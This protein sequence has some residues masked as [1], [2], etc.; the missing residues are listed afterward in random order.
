MLEMTFRFDMKNI[1]SQN[2]DS[3]DNGDFEAGIATKI[4]S[5]NKR[6][7]LYRVILLNDDYTPM[8]FV[9]HILQEIFNKSQDEA[10]II[11]LTVH[12]QGAGECGIFSFEIAET[13]VNQ[14]LDLA[15]KDQHPLKCVM[16]KQ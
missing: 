9:V 5:K 6:P 2:G 11:M 12:N 16:Q 1:S 3:E 14:V 4:H 8:E 10:M 13:K 7:A 15:K